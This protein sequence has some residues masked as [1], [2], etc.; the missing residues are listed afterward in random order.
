MKFPKLHFLRDISIFPKHHVVPPWKKENHRFKRVSHGRGYVILFWRVP[1][2][3]QTNIVG[4]KLDHVKMRFPNMEISADHVTLREGIHWWFFGGR[5]LL[6]SFAWVSFNF[7]WQHIIPWRQCD[8]VPTLK[9]AGLSACRGE[10][11]WESEIVQNFGCCYV[12]MYL[13]PP[14]KI[15][16]A[17][18]NSGWKMKVPLEMSFLWGCPDFLWADVFKARRWWYGVRG[19]L[20]IWRNSGKLRIKPSYFPLYWLGTRDPYVGLF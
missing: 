2:L 1:T 10:I 17:L 7:A 12:K 13:P 11:D 20:V 15:T 16:C 14:K 5:S 6:R 9:M 4:W 19:R 18:K 3:L 8:Q